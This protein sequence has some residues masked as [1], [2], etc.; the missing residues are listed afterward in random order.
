MSGPIV[1]TADP[2]EPIE[3][4][5]V[6]VDYLIHPPKAALAMRMA[7]ESKLYADDP[8]KMAQAL[9]GWVRKA[10]GKEYPALQARLDDETDLLDFPHVMTLMEK[11]MEAQTEPDPTS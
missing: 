2:V 3:V 6:G 7:I 10:F 8:E 11:V 9:D 1:I 4:S 5:L